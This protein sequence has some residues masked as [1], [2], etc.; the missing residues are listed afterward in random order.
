MSDRPDPRLD[1][2]LPIC[3]HRTHFTATVLGS[4]D[5]A[6]RAAGIVRVDT[7]DEALVKRLV[8]RQVHADWCCTEGCVQEGGLHQDVE[9][10][11]AQPI[12]GDVYPC[13]GTCTC[14]V[15]DGV[16]GTLAALREE[17]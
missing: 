10:S 8:A 11:D 6:D 9:F 17:S 12:L 4:L 1:V 2:L 13:P 14:Q 7:R 3:N 16:R 5:A 15:L